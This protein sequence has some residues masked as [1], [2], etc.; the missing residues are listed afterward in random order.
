[1]VFKD[2]TTGASSD[3][4]KVSSIARKI[5]TMY[6][7]NPKLGP[8]TYGKRN[9]H[10]F[11]GRDFGTERDYGEEVATIIDREVKM[12]VEEQYDYA[13]RL[14]TDNRDIVD[15][16]VK[17]LLEKET[18]DDKEVMDIIDE[19]KATRTNGT[20]RV[21]KEKL[22]AIDHSQDIPLIIQPSGGDESCATEPVTHPQDQN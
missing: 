21:P 9:E 13:K 14:L 8:I 3:L 22:D 10:S 5:V 6:G 11:M 7:M 18:L 12:L 4:E 2:I 20:G 15:A 19:V 17:I 1:V 16:I